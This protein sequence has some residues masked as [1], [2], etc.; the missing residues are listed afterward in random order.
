[1]EEENSK[2]RTR[3]ATDIRAEDLQP[4]GSSQS[5]LPRARLELT[6][7]LQVI[8]EMMSQGVIGRYAIGGAIGAT[9][10]L[11]PIMTMDVDVFVAIHPESGRQI[12]TS[13]PIYEYLSALGYE[14]VGDAIKIKD[15][16]VQFLPP[17]GPLGEEAI[18]QAREV[19]VADDVKTF[20]M[21]AEHLI[22][23]ALETGR[24]KDMARL[25]QFIEAKKFDSDGLHQ[26]L[27]RHGLVKRW[28]D[29]KKRF[30]QNQ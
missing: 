17:S 23:I 30:L 6:R 5:T 13:A 14:P 9:F 8:N 1:M 4:S 26:I 3:K 28:T 20:V 19:D 7:T 16:L 25:L 22:A 27:K 15:W 24:P 11:E 10:Y 18:A 29:F 12:I 21:T 2:I